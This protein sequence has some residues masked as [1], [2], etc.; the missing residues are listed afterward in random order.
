MSID[1]WLE[2]AIADAELRGLPDL[3][4]IL[5]GI[6]AAARALR[7]AGLS[8]HADGPTEH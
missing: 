3:K 6:A 1:E 4:P 8:G 7:D 5:E 2:A